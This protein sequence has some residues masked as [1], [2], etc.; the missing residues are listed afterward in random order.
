VSDPVA[1][2]GPQGVRLSKRMSEL[3]LASRRE[4]DAWIERGWVRVDGRVASEL[5]TRVLD[6]QRITL[7][8]RARRDQQARVT[9]LLHKPL[10]VVSG[11]AEDGHQPARTLVVP[12]RHW[13]GDRS[14]VAFAP[15]HRQGLVP[16]GRLDLDSTGLLVLTQDGRI[17]KQLIGEDSGIEKEYVVRVAPARGAPPL[18]ARSD[19]DLAP[20]RHGLALDGVALR[21]AVVE[22]IGPDRLRVVL[23]EGRKRQIRRMA[24]QVG[25]VVRELVRVR[26]GAVWLGDLP[27]GAWR[28]LGP[29]ERFDAAEAA[30]GPL[31]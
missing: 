13:H 28:F 12:Q 29:D 9:V 31:R 3:G 6:G 20:L 14:G 8:P 23:R 5:G 21:P 1:T 24:E 30:P 27:L 22:R 4:A 19:A 25:L 17:A 2:D 15:S 26:I 18:G 11:Q 7:D 10:G 16:A